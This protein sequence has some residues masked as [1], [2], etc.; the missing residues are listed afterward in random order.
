MQEDT[1][2][3]KIIKNIQLLSV[4]LLVMVSGKTVAGGLF[5][6]ASYIA[7]SVQIAEQEFKPTLL[8]VGIGWQFTDRFAVEI[9]QASAEAEDNVA[10]VT[11]EIE[12]MSSVMFRYGSPVNSD[13]NVYV[14]GGYSD[15][16][17]KT[18]GN[19]FSSTENFSGNSWGVGFEE[20]LSKKSNFRLHF[21]YLIHY[22]QDE[23]K[24][25]SYQLGMRYVFN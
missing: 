25:E 7:S 3:R 9:S 19:T 8:Q 16:D 24:V 11:S 22:N 21:D 1:R 6:D 12:T 2:L 4:L 17:L 5:V 23:L 10:T 20:R 14:M 15:L 18:T 13:V